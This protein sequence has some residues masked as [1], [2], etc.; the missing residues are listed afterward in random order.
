MS[1]DPDNP[2]TQ[3]WINMIQQDN[4]LDTGQAGDIFREIS[5]IVVRLG[6]DPPTSINFFKS[7]TLNRDIEPRK[8][9][10]ITFRV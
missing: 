3:P 4:T 1:T 6:N 7:P 2:I 9:D 8:G 10:I 5:D